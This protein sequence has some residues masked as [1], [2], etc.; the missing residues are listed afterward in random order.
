MAK[1]H[2]I[3][4]ALLSA[5]S[6]SVLLVA[7]HADDK[8]AKPAP[9]REIAATVNGQPIYLD[10]LEAQVQAG[11]HKYSK[12]NSGKTPQ[13]LR[14]Q[15]QS[16]VLDKYIAAEL[17]YQA[18]LKEKISDMDTKITNELAKRK[19][20]Q[21]NPNI[22]TVTRQIYID[23]YLVKN[24]LSNPQVPENEVKAYYEKNMQNFVS[25]TDV[26]HVRHILI[27]S[28]KN[29]KPAE[30]SRAQAKLRQVQQ[31]LKEGKAF[32]DVAKE[33]SE[34]ANAT[35]GGD[36]GNIERGYM[37]PEFEKVAFSMTPGAIS[38]TVRTEFGFHVIEVLEKRPAG[39]VPRLE[40][41]RD[42]LRQ[43][44]QQQLKAKNI[45]AHIKALEKKAKIEVLIPHEQ[46]KRQ[47]AQAFARDYD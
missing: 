20:A 11:L 44:L 2:R 13:A 45:T 4:I 7:A 16:K 47:Q 30:L 33:F 1:P 38:D 12:F 9:P 28:D 35:A 26:V 21:E 36:L 46:P 5:L 34:D 19:A 18:S 17:L 37:P 8:T 32:V 14:Q 15:I 27:Q 3:T 6:L 39:S 43:G 29:A 23:E 31:A 22:D 40:E 42:F 41:I 25:K 10:Q 24:N